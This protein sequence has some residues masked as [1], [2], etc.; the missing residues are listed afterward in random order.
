MDH[1][2]P[3]DGH[4]PSAACQAVRERLDAFVDG[5]LPAPDAH[6]DATLGPSQLAAHLDVC[7][8]CRVIAHQ[9]Q[10]QKQRLRLMATRTATRPEERASEALRERIERLRA[11]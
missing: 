3:L 9:L 4:F 1:P 6:D 11:G 7:P 8:P 5:E 2:A 10:A